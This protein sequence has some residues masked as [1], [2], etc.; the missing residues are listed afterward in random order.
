VAEGRKA[1]F[2]DL[3]HPADIAR[4]AS[5]ML[6]LEPLRGLVIIDEIQRL[7]KLFEVLRVLSEC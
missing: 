3:E 2:F 6:T 5:P 7:P 4:L 1:T